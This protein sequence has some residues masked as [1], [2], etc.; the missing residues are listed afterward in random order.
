VNIEDVKH[1]A[2]Y[3]R[4]STDKQDSSGKKVETEETLRNHKQKLTAYAEKHGY[5]YEIYQEV[6]TGGHS[7]IENRPQLNDL[8]NNIEKYDGI[9][10]VELSRLSRNGKISE[11][12][13]EYCQDYRKLIITPES[14]Y[15]LANNEM[16]VLMFRLGS[17]IS[18][19]ERSIIG[20]RI[21]NNKLEIAKSGLNASGSVPLGY[22]RNPKTKKLEIVEEE[23]DA[24]R[25]AF[26]L[27]LE[28]Y[29]ASKISNYLN[30]MGYKTKVGNEFTSRA[31]KDMLKTETYKGSTVYRDY[32]KTKRKGKTIKEVNDKIVVE[33]SHMPIVEPDVFDKVQKGLSKRAERYGNGREK[34]NTKRQPSILKDLLYC[35][36][37]GRK[38]AINYD[39]QRG[40]HLIRSCPKHERTNG[41]EV[42]NNN[43]FIAENVE[44]AVLEKLLEDKEQLKEDIERLSNGNMEQEVEEREKEKQRLE[45][46]IK[47]LDEEMKGIMRLELKYEM[48]NESDP[49]H[50][51]FIREQ[52]QENLDKRQRAKDQ[53]EEIE[54]KMQQPSPQDEIQSRQNTI[55]IIEGLD[56][57][58][59]EEVNRELKQIIKRIE[60]T[61]VLPD[62]ILK[63]GNKN[64]KRRD[65]PADIEIEYVE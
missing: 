26:R 45:T 7:E 23:A 62:E 18:D 56:G 10:A 4:I 59:P 61:R 3:V 50:E 5:T 32:T 53:L 49:M 35:S 11:L 54:I 20:K 36:I 52:K 58:K 24:V 30:D 40:V 65:Y 13:L 9:L 21:R 25:H 2:I 60:Y 39:G 28:G 64:P 15:D 12:L 57:K 8:L 1:V 41:G 42:C 37:C 6:V 19:H 34:P 43:G 17:A 14:Y 55:E 38:M 33:G 46:R 22:R 27:S 47:E 63:L 31:I 51:E 44:N 29:G 48:N 16:D